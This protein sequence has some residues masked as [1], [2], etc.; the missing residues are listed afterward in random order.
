MPIPK[1]G[2]IYNVGGK[3][4][5]LYPI[6]YLVSELNKALPDSTRTSQTIRLWERKRII[7]P[8]T[9]K[10]SG[11]RLYTKEQVDVIVRIAVEEDIRQGRKMENT[12]FSERVWEA[13]E[14]LANKGE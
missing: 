5:I 3:E 10:I 1:E 13:F 4:I 2:K 9:Y 6:S 8:A 7:P 11:I 14:E 12:N